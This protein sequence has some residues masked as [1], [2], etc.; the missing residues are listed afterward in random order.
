MNRSLEPTSIR[1]L[2]IAQ[3][4]DLLSQLAAGRRGSIERTGT[5]SAHGRVGELGI[6]S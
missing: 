4:Q 5:A 6:L 2:C 3:L 1:A